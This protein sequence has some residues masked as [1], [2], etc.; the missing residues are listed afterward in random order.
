MQTNKAAAPFQPCAK[1]AALLRS[2]HVAAD[3]VPHH[4]L[5]PGEL[6]RIEYG[7]IFRRVAAPATRPGN[8]LQRAICGD[9]LL[10]IAKA[11]R[12]RKDED[13]IAGK[14]GG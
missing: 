8:L 11:V 3:A 14:L 2:Q 9:D 10:I 5:E 1:G 6:R 7:G 4:R 12:L 13:S